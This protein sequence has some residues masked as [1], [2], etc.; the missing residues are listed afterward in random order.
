MNINNK[1]CISLGVFFWFFDVLFS[2]EY[3]IKIIKVFIIVSDYPDIS[4]N[5][6][7]GIYISR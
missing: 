6:N 2:W 1:L 4:E 5:S 3:K 7:I